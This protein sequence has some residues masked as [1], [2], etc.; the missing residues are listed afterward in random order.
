LIYLKIIFKTLISNTARF[1][2]NERTHVLDEATRNRRQRKALESLEKDNF[3]DAP[4]N[5]ND[6]RQQQNKKLQ[7]KFTIENDST[8]STTSS[9]TNLL[10]TNNSTNLSSTNI[11]ESVGKKRKIKPESKIKFR[12]NFNALIEEEVKSINFINF[13]K[14]NFF[15]INSNL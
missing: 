2:A 12:K 6:H 7:Q 11:N 9:T 10:S 3:Q 5:L 1:K 4:A 15:I 8:S 14:K 13:F